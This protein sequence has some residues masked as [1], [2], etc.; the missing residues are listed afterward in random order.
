MSLA[1]TL[2][3]W[4]FLLKM[5]RAFT[6]RSYVLV[7]SHYRPTMQTMLSGVHVQ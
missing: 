5:I 3:Y 6:R 7:T 4:H 2:K 1:F